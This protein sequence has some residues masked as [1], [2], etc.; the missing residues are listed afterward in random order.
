M[1]ALERRISNLEGNE[2]LVGP[3][4]IMDRLEA[5]LDGA[6]FRLMGKGWAE[7][8]TESRRHVVIDEVGDEFIAHQV[9]IEI[10]HDIAAGDQVEA[11]KRRVLDETVA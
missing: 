3:P 1:R 8:A 4:S 11:R 6:A 9:R 2:A 5:A 10:D 7:L